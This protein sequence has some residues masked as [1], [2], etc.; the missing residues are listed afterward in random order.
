MS[1]FDKH[2]LPE[3]ISLLREAALAPERWQNVIEALSEP[4]ENAA[5]IYHHFDAET[6]TVPASIRS[7]SSPEFLATYDQYYGAI[8]PYPAG[9]FMRSAPGT[10]IHASS[11]IPAHEAEKTEFMNDWM[12]PQGFGPT[13]F[14][15]TLWQD[16]SMMAL[17][18][19]VPPE[20][21]A[22]RKIDEMV[23]RFERIIPEMQR[24][25][26]TNRTVL[27]WARNAEIMETALDAIPVPAFVIDRKSRLVQANGKGEAL[28]NGPAKPL[29]VDP[30]SRIHA[31]TAAVQRRLEGHVKAAFE[32]R[33]EAQLSPLR[34]EC[35]RSGRAFVV[36][37]V[38]VEPRGDR[39]TI[40]D[41]LVSEPTLI[42]LLT[43][44]AHGM[45]VQPEQIRDA[46]GL[47]LAEARIVSA[48]VAGLTLS[49]YAEQAGLTRNTVRNQLA[50][51]FLKTG[52]DRQASLVATAVSAL[53]PWWES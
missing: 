41:H 9:A 12:A 13:H 45:H 40:V 1:K 17:I 43:P 34:V 3:I 20:R 6:H 19:I 8:N 48:L 52:T 5:C 29:R 46:L 53:S 47:T 35:P 32:L 16:S 36:R 42:M 51:A 14:G 49:E 25:L 7:G 26:D 44:I 33:N 31:S 38:P 15:T 30:S 21:M 50:S 39:S 23:Q 4:F 27:R 10:I 28:L 11:V 22:R 2:R 37:L 18:A 24:T